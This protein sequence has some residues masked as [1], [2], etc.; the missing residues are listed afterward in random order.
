[1]QARLALGEIEVGLGRTAAGRDRLA[2][3]EKAASARGLAL[4]ARKAAS[5]RR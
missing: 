1:L 5:A 2:A 4:I 3:V